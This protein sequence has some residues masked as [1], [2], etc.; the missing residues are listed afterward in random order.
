M[1]GEGVPVARYPYNTTAWQA[2]RKRVL[3]RDDYE[4]QLRYPCCLGRANTADHVIPVSRLPRWDPRLF[5]E[6]NLRA[7]CI[8]CNS[9][10]REG[11]GPR[12]RGRGEGRGR[13]RPAP[14]PE[15]T[16]HITRR[17]RNMHRS[18]RRISREW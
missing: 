17:N 1:A 6:N 5:D 3:K 13:P 12:P 14:D 9:A 4:C 2:V 18:T 7:A 11:R 15:G 16:G 8:P 10:R